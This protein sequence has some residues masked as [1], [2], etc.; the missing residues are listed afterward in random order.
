MLAAI[1]DCETTR[2]RLL[3][4]VV[5]LLLRSCRSPCHEAIKSAISRHLIQKLIDGADMGCFGYEYVG[6]SSSEW[7]AWVQAGG[8]IIAIFFA[9]KVANKQLRQQREDAVNARIN[10]IDKTSQFIDHCHSVLMKVKDWNSS[11]YAER[12]KTK[13]GQELKE[14]IAI[15]TRRLQEIPIQGLPAPMSMSYISSLERG[16]M[17]ASDSII[18][19]NIKESDDGAAATLEGFEKSLTAAITVAALISTECLSNMISLKESING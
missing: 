19:A 17:I 7:A 10:E 4:T 14:E 2:Q 16:L 13:W 11:P 5:F 15:L 8:S 12:Q 9:G 18:K 1:G 3:E 6:M